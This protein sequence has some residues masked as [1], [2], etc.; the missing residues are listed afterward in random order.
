MLSF[1]GMSAGAAAVRIVISFVIGILGCA[2]GLEFSG[3]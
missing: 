1:S 2:D 3:L